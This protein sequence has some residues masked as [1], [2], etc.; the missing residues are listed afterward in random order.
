MGRGVIAIP[1]KGD[2]LRLMDVVPIESPHEKRVAEVAELRA[3][4]PDKGNA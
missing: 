3:A 2:S 1:G 4:P